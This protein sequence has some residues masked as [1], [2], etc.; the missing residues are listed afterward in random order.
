MFFPFPCIFLCREDDSVTLLLV[1]E[2]FF[3]L[4]FGNCLFNIVSIRCCLGNYFCGGCKMAGKGRPKGTTGRKWK[5]R[6]KNIAV[7]KRHELILEATVLLVRDGINI[8]VPRIF[9]LIQRIVKKDSRFSEVMVI[10]ER[11]EHPE[12]KEKYFNKSGKQL[13]PSYCIDLKFV[14]RMFTLGSFKCWLDKSISAEL[15]FNSRARREWLRCKLID[16]AEKGEKWAIEYLL[17]Y[18]GVALSEEQ[19][20][21]YDSYSEEERKNIWLSKLWEKS[22]LEGDLKSL[23]TLGKQFGWYDETREE[24]AG[25]AE[26]YNVLDLRR[27]IDMLKHE[28]KH[29]E[30]M[31]K[32]LK[33]IEYV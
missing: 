10:N 20:V 21:N 14:R 19:Q 25:L 27:E 9:E 11:N 22:I 2:G 28:L 5:N 16:A 3:L 32:E 33:G 18:G 12:L 7:D 8:Q 4:T 26:Y 17:K 6:D 13:G 23:I 30:D 1:E 24:D 15:G 29:S 31:I